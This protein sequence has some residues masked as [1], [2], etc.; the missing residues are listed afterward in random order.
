V[1]IFDE[2]SAATSDADSGWPDLTVRFSDI[3]A[4]PATY[5]WRGV[6]PNRT[7]TVVAGPGGTGKGIAVAAIEALVTT[8]APFP[9]ETEEREPGQVIKIAPE[10]DANEDTAFRLIAAG[11]NL[12]LVRN[13][14]VLPSGALFRLPDN[15]GDLD[16]AVTEINDEGGPPVRLITVDPLL[17]TCTA[18]I[19]R[20]DPRT[21]IE[22]LQNLAAET[23]TAVLASHHTT[24]NPEVIAGGQAL[25]DA[26]RLVW[27]IRRAKD[28]EHARTMTVYKTNRRAHPQLRF[29]IEGDDEE[30]R[31]VFVTSE[32]KTPGSRAAKLRL[33]K[34]PEETAVAAQQWLDEHKESEE[35]AS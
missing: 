32:S 26:S 20:S 19:L 18:R 7:V 3:P 15:I 8:G 17:A 6:I 27:L 14:T 35:K 23:G 9:G 5:L 24:K 25:I 11:A 4:I 2:L 28:D 34:T 31:A 13:L 12:E 16:Q 10:D 1:S 22:P 30:A 21:V 29:R 33:V